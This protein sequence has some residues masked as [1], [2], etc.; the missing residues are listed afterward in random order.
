MVIMEVIVGYYTNSRTLIIES[1]HMLSDLSAVWVAT[2]SYRMSSVKWT[3]STFGFARAETLGTFV[4][5]VFFTATCFTNILHCIREILMQTSIKSPLLL[6]GV[7]TMGLFFNIFELILFHGV[8]KNKTLPHE[9]HSHYHVTQWLPTCNTS[10]VEH[11]IDDNKTSPSE[12]SGCT[13]FFFVLVSDAIGS[14]MVVIVGGF[15]L[16]LDKKYSE[17]IDPI[18]ASLLIFIILYTMW[19]IFRQSANILLQSVPVHLTI[20]DLK[21][22]NYFLSLSKYLSYRNK[23][24]SFTIK[25]SEF[26]Y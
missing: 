1:F 10:N 7:G 14:L 12:E 15:I 24:N 2:L 9:G 22:N 25:Q 8:T 17:I 21:V 18:F 6:V 19:P 13:S 26:V 23:Y 3:R 20:N 11:G 16:I 5:C 4:N